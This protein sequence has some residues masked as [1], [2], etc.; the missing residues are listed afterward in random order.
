[1]TTNANPLATARSNVTQRIERFIVKR[2]KMHPCDSD[3]WEYEHG[4]DLGAA[5][6]RA[7]MA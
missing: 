2:L 5:M 1:M 6:V 4:Q 7:G 3:R